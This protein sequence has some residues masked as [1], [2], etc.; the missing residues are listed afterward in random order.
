MA[1]L[2][3]KDRNNQKWVD[4]NKMTGKGQAV[5]GNKKFHDK[6]LTGGD[7]HSHQKH[8]RLNNKEEIVTNM[9][10]ENLEHKKFQQKQFGKTID[11]LPKEFGDRHSKKQLKKSKTQYNA[12]FENSSFLNKD[13]IENDIFDRTKD[14]TIENDFNNVDDEMSTKRKNA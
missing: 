4:E 3:P 14:K 6:T 8:T 9:L 10:N 1:K 7:I 13:G 11:S 12:T 2:K 5:W